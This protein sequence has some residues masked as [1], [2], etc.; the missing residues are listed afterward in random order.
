MRNITVFLRSILLPA[1]FLKLMLEF[2]STFD[3]PD[4]ELKTEVEA[5]RPLLPYII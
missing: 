5:G 3:L 1:S 4:N 2:I